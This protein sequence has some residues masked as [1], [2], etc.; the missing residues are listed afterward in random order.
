MKLTN[1][2]LKFYR[3]SDIYELIVKHMEGFNEGVKI[4]FGPFLMFFPRKPE[5]VKIILNSE[6]CQDKPL[7]FYRELFTYGLIAMNGDEYKAHRK[8][9]NPLFSPKALRSYIPMLDDV[10]NKFLVDFDMNLKSETFDLSYD[11][12]DYT[13]NGNLVT[14]FGIDVEKSIRAD[15]LKRS[16]E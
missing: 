6:D 1:L 12:M 2:L 10:M 8:A 9:F 5:D 4:W 3:S 7:F 14:F 15:F 16:R 11:T 13:F